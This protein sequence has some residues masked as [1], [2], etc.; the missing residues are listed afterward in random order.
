MPVEPHVV[1]LERVRTDGSHLRADCQGRLCDVNE[2]LWRV[3]WC[4]VRLRATGWASGAEHAGYFTLWQRCRSFWRLRESLWRSHRNHRRSV[5]IC[6]AFDGNRMYNLISAA[7]L[8]K[9]HF[10]NIQFYRR[11][12]LT[13]PELN[14]FHA[15]QCFLITNYSTQHFSFFLF[16]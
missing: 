2:H 1:S 11:R 16:F 8:L 9:I 14:D 10:K 13:I 6:H 4:P 3:C 12:L 15:V 5:G 7:Y